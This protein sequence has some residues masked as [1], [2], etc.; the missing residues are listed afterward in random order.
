MTDTK[1]LTAWNG[2]MIRGFA[3]AGRELKEPKY[4][5]A[6]ERAANFVWDHLRRDD[7][8][9]WRIYG[10]GKAKLNAY[11]D[12]YALSDRRPHCVAPRRPDRRS[13]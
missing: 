3:D 6:A 4:I 7:G 11:I 13:G 1:I 12:D 9:L 2:L 5:A 10:Q 8:R